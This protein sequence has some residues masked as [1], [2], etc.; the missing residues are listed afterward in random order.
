M[1]AGRCSPAL[2]PRSRPS[3]SSP[4]RWKRSSF[5]RH[6]ARRRRTAGRRR[7]RRGT[8]LAGPRLVRRHEA[9]QAGHQCQ[10]HA[11]HL[12]AD[13]RRGRALIG[14]RRG[15]RRRPH[16][17]GC[18]R[19]ATPCFCA[20]T[21]RG[22]RSTSV[23]EPSSAATIGHGHA[24]GMPAHTRATMIAPGNGSRHRRPSPLSI[25][26]GDPHARANLLEP[27]TPNPRTSRAL[28]RAPYGQTLARRGPGAAR[29]AAGSA[30]WGRRR[31]RDTQQGQAA[32]TGRRLAAPT[33]AFING[34]GC[35]AA[36]L[37]NGSGCAA[38]SIW[39]G[40]VGRCQQG[41]QAHIGCLCPACSV[42]PMPA[43][44]PGRPYAGVPGRRRTVYWFHSY[45]APYARR[46]A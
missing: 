14:S 13:H 31:A 33:S 38:A 28:L 2:S 26:G 12:R 24:V 3:P 8:A 37:I 21:A 18:P 42:T 19:L 40:P 20:R 32:A 1:I 22:L 7:G 15:Q 5:P 10:R 46:S 35:A 34:G 43:A 9:A 17:S 27:A 30:G 45:T 41:S 39:G 44:V 25:A 16:R 6:L 29:P 36:V 11:L 4:C 23:P